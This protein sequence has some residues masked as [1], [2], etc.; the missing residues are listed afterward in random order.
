MSKNY[1]NLM[2]QQLNDHFDSILSPKQCDIRKDH[3]AQ[4]CL[5]VMV[6]KFTESRERGDEFGILFTDLPKAFDCI[7]HNV[8]ITKLSRY[9]VTTKSLNLI[10][11]I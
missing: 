3:S 9:R 7:D 6:E 2:C 8:L 10:F 1:E 4:Y 11:F 5:M